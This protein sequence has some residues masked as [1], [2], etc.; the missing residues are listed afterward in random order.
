MNVV[1]INES[2][3]LKNLN[4]ARRNAVKMNQSSGNFYEI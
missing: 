3:S 2:V 4:P 1:I